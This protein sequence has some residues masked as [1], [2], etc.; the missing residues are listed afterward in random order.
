MV[1]KIRMDVHNY[2]RLKKVK[3]KKSKEGQ[4][5]VRYNNYTKFKFQQP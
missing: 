3:K 1:H 5:I 4:Y 2:K